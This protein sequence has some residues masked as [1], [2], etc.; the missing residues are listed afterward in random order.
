MNPNMSSF[1]KRAA[2]VR[3]TIKRTSSG[4]PR[5]S[6]FKSNRN[7]YAQII[8]DSSGKTI[9]SASTMDEG[10]RSTIQGKNKEAARAIGAEIAQ[11]ALEK[12]VKD[13][14]FDRGGYCYHG[15]VKALADAARGGGL[16][17]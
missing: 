10:L 1:K 7:I 6:V 3:I 11:R 12:G 16:N 5:L 8:D 2:R 15:A 13:V 9:A 4:R 17:F 14:V